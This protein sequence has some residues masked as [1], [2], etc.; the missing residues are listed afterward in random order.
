MKR[1]RDAEEE[2]SDKIKEI[3]KDIEKLNNSKEYYINGVTKLPLIKLNDETILKFPFETTEEIKKLTKESNFGMGTETKNDK[4]IRSSLE[5]ESK[6]IKI[7]EGNKDL[8]NNNNTSKNNEL[9]ET[10][11]KKL[12]PETNVIESELYKLLIYEKGDHFKAHK[13]TIRKKNHFATLIL[14]LPSCKFY[15]INF[16]KNKK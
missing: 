16:K 8:L 14:F 11:R 12:C 7:L 3:K 2:I 9:L 15:Y 1:K 13:D 4:E 5:I 10:I 6:F